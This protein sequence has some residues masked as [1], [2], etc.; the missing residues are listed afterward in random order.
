[1]G[2]ACG[3]R[4][5]PAPPALKKEKLCSMV[6]SFALASPRV[7]GQLASGRLGSARVERVEERMDS[8]VIQM[9][10][11]LKQ[12]TTIALEN[13]MLTFS[14]EIGCQSRPKP[15]A[16]RPHPGLAGR[17]PPGHANALSG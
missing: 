16:A 5:D 11:H 4:D 9:S 7:G 12:L 14:S 1:V 2:N 17:R 13:T 10:H 6:L 8:E 15:G 3:V